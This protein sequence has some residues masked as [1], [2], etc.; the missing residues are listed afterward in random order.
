VVVR[1]PGSQVSGEELVASIADQ[2]PKW[3]LPDRVE[4]VDEIP[5]TA[6]GKFSK[7]TLR[8]RLVGGLDNNRDS[9]ER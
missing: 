3:W 1:R 9:D 5:M 8:E 6:T 7:R 4:F 2:F